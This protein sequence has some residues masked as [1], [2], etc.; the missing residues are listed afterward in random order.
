MVSGVTVALHFQS[1]S[2]IIWIETLLLY[3]IGVF[4]VDLHHII[5]ESVY[6]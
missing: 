4:Q 2:F 3:C 5:F 1:T 6:S